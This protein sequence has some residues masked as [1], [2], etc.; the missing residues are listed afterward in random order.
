MSNFIS[1]FPSDL[2]YAIVAMAAAC[3]LP[4]VFAFWAK[5]AGGFD[6]K[7]DNAN[8]RAFFAQSKGLSARLNA[9][10]LNSFESLPIF[11]ASV[12]LAMYCF[13]PQNVVNA[14][15][16]LYVALRVLYGFAYAFDMATFRSVIWALSLLCSL[17]LFYFS[18]VM[19]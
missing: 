19:V 16:W 11:L 7:N 3:V 15:A 10:Q 1:I 4:F 17:M 6:F 9:A 12:L 14:L 2:A 5:M 8:P 18:L 13:V